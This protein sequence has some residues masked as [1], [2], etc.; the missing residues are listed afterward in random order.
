MTNINLYDTNNNRIKLLCGKCMIANNENWIQCM[1]IKIN[2]DDSKTGE[3]IDNRLLTP[4]TNYVKVFNLT[5]YIKQEEF[6]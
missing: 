6:I 1:L 5:K 4:V 2:M 3:A